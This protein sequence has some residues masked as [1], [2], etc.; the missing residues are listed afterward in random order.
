MAETFLTD[1]KVTFVT[2][3]QGRT[4]PMTTALVVVRD[5]Q[6]KSAPRVLRALLDSGGS[7][8]MASEKVLPPGTTA[9]PEPMEMVNTLA[10]HMT[11]QGSVTMTGLRLPE[12]IFVPFR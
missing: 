9:T 11:T 12:F 5:I 10:G 3:A 8:C 6:G 4:V 2:D 1:P 7:G